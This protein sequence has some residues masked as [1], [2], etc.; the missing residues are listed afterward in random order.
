MEKVKEIE[1]LQSL[2]GDTYFAQLFGDEQIDAMCENIRN[3]YP[4]EC[5]LNLFQSSS[6]A[7]ENTE[8]K[9]RL[10]SC[11]EREESVA[12]DILCK[13]NE[14]M[15]Y[16]LV[17]IATRLIGYEKCLAIKLQNAVPLTDEDRDFLVKLLPDVTL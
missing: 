9:K 3:D 1:L 2:K 14:H 15:D 4:I 7:K 8:L 11:S 17:D 16:S 6:V 5:G 13:A 10:A 12:K